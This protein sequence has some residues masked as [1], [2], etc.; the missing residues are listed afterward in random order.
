[1]TLHRKRI[2][3]SRCSLSPY[4]VTAAP[5]TVVIVPVLGNQ[6]LKES[7][8][9]RQNVQWN[10]L[11]R[12]WREMERKPQ[13]QIVQRPGEPAG[14]SH[15]H[16]QLPASLPA[17]RLREGGLLP[18]P[19]Q[20]GRPRSPEC[21]SE[22]VQSPPAPLISGFSGTSL[23]LSVRALSLPHHCPCS[24]PPCHG[25]LVQLGSRPQS[26]AWNPLAPGPN[27]RKL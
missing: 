16:L 13:S 19:C 18:S 25:K 20:Q 4:I 5:R 8:Y 26:H 10:I 15:T 27:L 12:L 21:I 24:G 3:T 14:P 2:S 17:S 6:G 7:R 11:L 22:Q 9:S 23:L 1:M